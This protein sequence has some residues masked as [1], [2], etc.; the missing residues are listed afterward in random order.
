MKQL[1]LILALIS[2]LL[3]CTNNKKSDTI[4]TTKQAP[5]LM[6]EVK[7]QPTEVISTDDQVTELVDTD[8]EAIEEP[9]QDI[10][11]KDSITSINMQL[12]FEKS[13]KK[14]R[15]ILAVTQMRNFLEQE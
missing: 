12:K 5:L 14:H 8:V 3:S 9:E 7:D 1:I 15:L 6:E 10:T 13:S 11:A 2:S 4:D